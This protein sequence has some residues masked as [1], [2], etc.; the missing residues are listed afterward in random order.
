[1]RN[2]IIGTTLFAL[3]VIVAGSLES[4]RIASA[5]LSLLKGAAPS[6]PSATGQ[7]VGSMIL[8]SGKEEQ[9]RCT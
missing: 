5:D 8:G 4:S 3:G 9:R 6:T 7:S 1:M 2:V